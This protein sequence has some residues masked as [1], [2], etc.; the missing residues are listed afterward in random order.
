MFFERE[1][2]NRGSVNS[3]VSHQGSWRLWNAGVTHDFGEHEHS[4]EMSAVPSAFAKAFFVTVSRH[5]VSGLSAEHENL[6]RFLIGRSAKPLG[7]R[8]T[9]G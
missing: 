1:L 5:H 4:Q 6:D 3:L 8:G 2:Q 7:E 9:L